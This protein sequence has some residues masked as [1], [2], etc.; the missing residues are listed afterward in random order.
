MKSIT[1]L[2]LLLRSRTH[3]TLSPVLHII[4][5]RCLLKH[6]NRLPFLHSLCI[7]N[8]V[9][10]QKLMIGMCTA[11]TEECK[12]SA[13]F[14]CIF[15]CPV[16]TNTLYSNSVDRNVPSQIN[17]RNLFYSKTFVSSNEFLHYTVPIH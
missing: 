8:P 4:N 11:V 12:F 13:S 10:N 7:N 6:M 15:L 17:S 3:G 5:T 14:S 9:A 16:I 2:Q 1:H